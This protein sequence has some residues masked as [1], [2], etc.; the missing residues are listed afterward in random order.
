M[1]SHPKLPGRKVLWDDVCRETFSVVGVVGTLHHGVELWRAEARFD[2]EVIYGFQ[3]LKELRQGCQVGEIRLS[4]GIIDRVGRLD[5]IPDLK[6][7]T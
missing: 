5:Q 7:R 4:G 3:V 1:D 2:P 6:R